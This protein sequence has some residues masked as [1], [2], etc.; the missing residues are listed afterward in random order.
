M[1]KLFTI[2]FVI[3]SSISFGQGLNLEFQGKIDYDNT[4][5]TKLSDIWGYVDEFGNEYG[6]VGARKGV[7][8]V[9]VTDPLNPT[10]VFWHPDTE[11][12]WR[13]L[14]T[15]GDY[16]YVTTEANSGLLIIDLTPLPD[17]PITTTT[18]FFG[19]PGQTWSTAHNLYIDENGFCYIFG[20]GRGNGGVII[21]DVATDPMNPIEVGEFDS[22]Y[23]HDGYVRGNL[24]YL[25]HIYEGTFSIVDITDKSNPI[26]LGT[27]TTSSNFA[28]NIW[29]SD[30]GNFVFTTDEISGAF[31]D[32]YDVSDPANIFRTDKIQSNPGV[33]TVPHNAHVLGDFLITSYYAD[34]VTIH[35]ISDPYSMIEVGN[36]DT[37]PGTSENTTGCWGAYPFLPSGNI[38]ATDI[39][40]GFYVLAP[41]Y[42]LAGRLE[43]NIVNAV[44]MNPL[45]GVEVA[46]QGDNQLEFSNLIGDY[47]TGII[48]EGILDVTYSRYGYFPQT[49]PVSFVNAT[50]VI[51]DVQ[52]V[53]IT[54]FYVAIKAQDIAN[55]PILNASV[56][57]EHDGVILE[58]L[59]NGLGE[60]VFELFYFDDYEV[61]VGKWGNISDC[62]SLFLD[63]STPELIVN[64]E[65][66][67]Y[68]D[69]AFDFGWSAFGDA[70]FGLWERAIPVYVEIGG[71]LS[72]NPSQDSEN[73]CAEYAYVTGNLPFAYD[74]VTNGTVTLISPVWDATI[75]TDPCVY[76]E[77]W[78]FNFLGD[79]APDDTIRVVL[80]NG[81]DMIE[82]DKE[83]SE[84]DQVETWVPV[85][86]R[87]TDF[88]TPTSTMQL[89]VNISDLAPNNNATEGGFDNFRVTEGEYLSVENQMLVDGSASYAYPNPF[90]NSIQLA[91][92]ELGTSFVLMD[93]KGA[94]LVEGKVTS[95]QTKINTEHL[96]KGIYIIKTSDDVFK[97]VK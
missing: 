83:G 23:V 18:N 61:T 40:T 28:H 9:D 2:A 76:Y 11:S 80:S 32:A 37:H 39:S 21:Y 71:G 54:P 27:Q 63:Q 60:A 41:D 1:N 51:Q 67:Y 31:L 42:K 64:L 17:N 49:I 62:Q 10:E 43:G 5:N 59:T 66:G 57:V 8:V 74:N 48:Q 25:A 16:A 79:L 87:I 6:L 33:G 81:T 96:P 53:P 88:M 30:D 70:D 45:N 93:A 90:S 13:D 3:F 82:I 78:F 94:I 86:K 72:S 36:F 97:M 65:T 69:F 29:P 34:G 20:S 84:I 58:Q 95:E 24:M 26:L 15:W 47:K 44:S 46:I 85:S 89:F 68:D 52:L 7:A 92:I 91:G 75:Y 35:D 55:N 4:R 50:T 22:W 38:L 14:K 19:H 56:R 12:I 77:R 73:D